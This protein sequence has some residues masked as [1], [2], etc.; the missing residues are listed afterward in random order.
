MTQ[1]ETKI[2]NVLRVV[3]TVTPDALTEQGEIAHEEGWELMRVMVLDGI[4]EEVARLPY[5]Y[6]P[7]VSAIE[8]EGEQPA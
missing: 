6:Q 7:E 8:W 1:T 4:A 3:L 2:N 5:D